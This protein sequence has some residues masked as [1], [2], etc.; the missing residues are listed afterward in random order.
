MNGSGVFNGKPP[1][2]KDI[3]ISNV[4]GKNVELFNISG[5]QGQKIWDTRN[6]RPG[7][8]LYL[9]TVNGFTESGKIVISK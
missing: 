3:R 5:V 9:F 6:I 8:Y 4:S 2:M 1:F 7:V